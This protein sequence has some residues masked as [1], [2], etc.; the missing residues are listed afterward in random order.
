MATEQEIME[1][2]LVDNS[3]KYKLYSYQ[4]SKSCCAINAR[5]CYFFSSTKQ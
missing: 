4:F 5:Q 1:S 2:V 3:I